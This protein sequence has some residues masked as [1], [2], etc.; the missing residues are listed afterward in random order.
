MHLDSEA[1]P[2]LR[3][4]P[5]QRQVA[6]EVFADGV[7]CSPTAS[8]SAI[9]RLQPHLQ[10]PTT[11]TSPLRRSDATLRTGGTVAG[12]VRQP[13]GRALL[14]APQVETIGGDLPPGTREKVLFDNLTP[15]YPNERLELEHESSNMTTRIIDLLT[16]IGKG[17]RCLIVAPPRAGKTVLLQDLA[18]AITA[19]HPEVALIVLLIDE[20]PEEVTDM[21]RSVKGEVVS[22][23]FDEPATRHV[24]VAE[25]VIEKA[26][27]LVECGTWTW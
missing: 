9:A 6:G 4:P 3:D 10:D 12:H 20:R 21:E 26:K 25:M 14:R 16:P 24:Q 17:Q 18:H 13:K 19:N 5:G 2:D 11:S 15:L 27:R 7:E 22:S 23:T 8:V 1:G